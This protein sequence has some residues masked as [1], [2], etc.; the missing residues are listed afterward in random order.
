MTDYVKKKNDDLSALCKD[1]GLPHG[2]KKADLVKRLEDYDAT[3]STSA[4]AATTTT[5]TTTSAEDEEI[6]WDEE[7]AAATTA[8]AA[9]AIAA[10]GIGEVK[11][12]AAVPNQSIVED[13]ATTNDLSVTNPDAAATAPAKEGEEEEAEKV[14]GKDFT[15]GLADRT[16]DEE[17][18]KRKARARK[19]GLAEDSDEIRL[20]E[21][22]KKFGVQDASLVPGMLNQALSTQRERGERKRGT[23]AGGLDVPLSEESG[24]RKRGGG[25]GRG[26]RGGTG[27]RR[28]GGANGG[29]GRER[30]RTPLE[31]RGKSGGGGGGAKASGN[32]SWMTEADKAKA[33]ARKARFAG[34]G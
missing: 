26:G 13:P 34:T 10:G 33:E 23:G 11:N 24:V 30:S 9:D 6:D 25:A 21:R 1:R 32:G 5:T 8:P 20:L 7:P 2:G 12:P 14:P 29:A 18:E 19:F 4:P 31:G 22:A 15:S 27:G 3:H 17:I 16:I 28:D